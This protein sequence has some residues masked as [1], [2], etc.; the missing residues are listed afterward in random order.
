MVNTTVF[1]AWESN[2]NLHG[3]AHTSSRKQAREARRRK[4]RIQLATALIEAD[5][6]Q[7]QRR[8]E[9]VSTME[10]ESIATIEQ[11]S[12]LEKSSNTSVLFRDA[13]KHQSEGYERPIYMQPLQSMREIT[14]A[15]LGMDARWMEETEDETKEQAP[16]RE[17]DTAT[18][19]ARLTIS[20]QVLQSPLLELSAWNTPELSA[21]DGTDTSHQTQPPSSP[22]LRPSA[23]MPSLFS[24]AKDLA[25]ELDFDDAPPSRASLLFAR[26]QEAQTK[27]FVGS[28]DVD[29]SVDWAPV[30][31]SSPTPEFS[32]P[33]GESVAPPAARP[34]DPGLQA[35]RAR[36][37][38][39]RRTSRRHSLSA[40]DWPGE[41]H[42]LEA[43][44][45]VQEDIA[46]HTPQTASQNGADPHFNIAPMLARRQTQREDDLSSSTWR[47]PNKLKKLLF[48]ER[49]K[50]KHSTRVVSDTLD[51]ASEAQA[52]A[53]LRA[54]QDPSPIPDTNFAQF[55]QHLALAEDDMIG[56][57][58]V[59]PQVHQG[60]DE[61]CNAP[62][63]ATREPDAGEFYEAP[64]L[65]P[66]HTHTYIPPYICIPA[67]LASTPREIPPLGAFYVPQGAFYVNDHGMILPRN[68]TRDT[69]YLEYDYGPVTVPFGIGRRVLYPSTALFRNVLVRRD[70]D[71]HGWGFERF[72]STLE[73]FGRMAPNDDDSDDDVPLM[74]VRIQT[75]EEH[76]AKRRM[77]R[78]R[79]RRRN[80]R[81]ERN[82][83]RLLAQKKGK[84][85]TAFGIDKESFSEESEHMST[86]C[87]DTTSEESDPEQPWKDDRRP[88]GKLYGQS[89][90]GL[91]KQQAERRETQVRFYG[92]L[93]LQG[94]RHSA[95]PET[96][97]GFYN[98]T[99]GRMQQVFGDLQQW[100]E[101]LA[102][103]LRQD[104][105]EPL[106]RKKSNA[107]DMMRISEDDAAQMLAHPGVQEAVVFPT[108]QE[109]IEA[110]AREAD[111][112][113]KQE[114]A[115]WHESGSED[116]MPRAGSVKPTRTSTRFDKGKPR[117]MEKEEDDVPL[118]RLRPQSIGVLDEYQS[119]SGEDE[120]PLASRHPQAAIIAE[121]QALIRQLLEENRQVRMSLQMLSSFPYG[122]NIAP[123]SWMPPLGTFAKTDA[124]PSVLDEDDVPLIQVE[125][126]D[127]GAA[128]FHESNVCSAK[129][130]CDERAAEDHAHT[131]EL[132]HA[133]RA[134][135]SGQ[136]LKGAQ[137][138]VYK[139]R[140]G[141]LDTINGSARV[142][143]QELR[144]GS[145]E[146][147]VARQDFEAVPAP[148]QDPEA[149]PA[150]LQ[151]S[152]AVPAPLHVSEEALAFEKE[153]DFFRDAN[154]VH[155]GLA[156]GP[157]S[158]R[159]E[160]MRA[161][162]Y[163]AYPPNEYWHH[164]YAS[165]DPYM[166]YHY[167]Y[168]QDG[169]V[170]GY[171]GQGCDVPCIG[172]GHEQ[173][174]GYEYDQAGYEYQNTGY[175]YD[176]ADY[177]YQNAGQNY[178]QAGYGHDQAG[179]EYQN[180][181]YEY[182][183]A[184]YGHDQAGSDYANRYD[185]PQGA[186]S[187]SYS[188]SYPI[189][190]CDVEDMANTHHDIV[191]DTNF[192]PDKPNSHAADP[193]S[194][195]PCISSKAIETDVFAWLSSPDPASA[196]DKALAEAA[197][198]ADKPPNTNRCMLEN[199]P[200]HSV[201]LTAS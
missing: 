162:G 176:Q 191:H 58:L 195:P 65:D 43:A 105:A 92:Q 1:D 19:L 63:A 18:E 98:D 31:A 14:R 104:G 8:I 96:L 165:H 25:S 174:A 117:W 113:D 77:H 135:E 95:P 183:Q 161:N 71:R 29:V 13:H 186:Y 155:T 17:N 74:D 188:S 199:D 125:A 72:T 87:S 133:E 54:L 193:P 73:Y 81:Q 10:P 102:R 100:D 111:E 131:A 200:T 169:Y 197:P 30:D 139:G 114:I 53:P 33:F 16:C 99:R 55:P 32:N 37:L 118:A 89:L 36:V 189:P 173:D 178:D 70:V 28:P 66:A 88:A 158:Q 85:V 156:L 4:H 23:S 198:S 3:S 78:E 57:S 147:Q 187:H 124:F 160:N 128:S 103:R 123:E 194:V 39:Q 9:F 116:D 136:V 137:E 48:K 49:R 91:A 157:E 68:K 21:E 6:E 171:D 143:A 166:A 22:A 56:V 83:L 122:V 109:A 94:N 46:N 190:D 152:E 107:S 69:A 115:A 153:I 52:H 112:R 108:V 146:T 2:N 5:N 76:L 7:I 62:Q 60:A 26:I 130:A 106:V 44:H 15:F 140:E 149:V 27:P 148:L 145:G 192:T 120:E 129:A 20:P 134:Q 167:G 184:G 64:A 12:Q 142:E 121:N 24:G 34:I 80:A 42:A 82:R 11:L 154:P 41:V 201:V 38:P 175:E 150:P 79:M 127:A 196:K 177:E 97:N 45:A 180:T 141:A 182:D 84:P 126:S 40:S 185:H 86:D 35:F 101:E 90:V 168:V 172:Y 181:G 138:K 164:Y 61:T 170:H 51:R 93:N 159:T 144:K 132:M 110:Q 47:R 67:P 179:Y 75:R 50:A 163:D 59:S 151:D 119:D